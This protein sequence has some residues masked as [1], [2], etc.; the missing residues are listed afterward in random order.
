M[1]NIPG[2]DLC[3]VN[4]ESGD[5]IQVPTFDGS[6]SVIPDSH[7]Y[8]NCRPIS[9]FEKLGKIS[10]GHFGTLYKCRDKR[11]NEII[12]LKKLKMPSEIED[13]IPSSIL[14]EINIINSLKHVNVLNSHG[15]VAGRSL[16]SNYLVL[17]YCAYSLDDLIEKNIDAISD[18]SVVKCIMKQLFEG[19]EYIHTGLI[20]HRNIT[21]QNIL[22]HE[23][24]ILKITGFHSSRF[25]AKGNMTPGITQLEYR[26]PELLFGVKKYETSSDMWSTG[27]V[28]AKLILKKFLF[29]GTT[30]LEV[31]SSI[32]DIL[33]TPSDVIWPGFNE[34]LAQ[35]ENGAFVLS[36]NKLFSDLKRCFVGQSAACKDLIQD[37]LLYYPT[38]RLTAEE[39]QKCFYFTEGPKEC[40]IEDLSS[41]LQKID[42]PPAEPMVTE[43]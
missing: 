25:Y 1:S 38:A 10:E 34:I 11:T 35:Y 2:L 39:C 28:F 26:A 33:G 42:L 19:L 23:T 36:S 30:E 24:G 6:I 20:V 8:G 7:R 12:S 9:D 31:L 16:T 29:S 22:F 5:G 3:P 15:T 27:C 14:R 32:F 21:C 43:N 37:L 4:E 13:G 41:I 17:D 18:Q 40:P